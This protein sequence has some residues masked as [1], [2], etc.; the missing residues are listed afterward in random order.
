METCAK[1]VANLAVVEHV[2]ADE[3]H[4][5]V[6]VRF[7]VLNPVFEPPAA[8]VLVAILPLPTLPEDSGVVLRQLFEAELSDQ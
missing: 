2:P 5:D 3:S 1:I 4:L 6:S 7:V 8:K